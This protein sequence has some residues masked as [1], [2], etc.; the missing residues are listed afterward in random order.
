MKKQ[1][2]NNFAPNINQ[3]NEN[4]TAVVNE[5]QIGTSA[6]EKTFTAADMWNIQRRSVT[7]FQ[8]RNCA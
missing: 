6:Q 5:G 7:M 1:L 2:E 8:R 3:S 4:L